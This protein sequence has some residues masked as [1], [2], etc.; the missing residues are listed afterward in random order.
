MT[1]KARATERGNIIKTGGGPSDLPPTSQ[2]G[3]I[4]SMVE[5]RWDC[6]DLEDF[7]AKLENGQT[8]TVEPD[9]TLEQN[10]ECEDVIELHTATSKSSNYE[11]AEKRKP[12]DY[13]RKEGVQRL[14]HFEIK[15][16]IELQILKANVR[17]C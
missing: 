12:L 8:N 16:K 4:I 6:L 7:E 10:I 17:T 11:L 9:V 15:K 2:Q 1:R 13:I 14:K 5:E 3:A